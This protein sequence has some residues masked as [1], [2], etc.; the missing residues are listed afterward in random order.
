MSLATGQLPFCG[1]RPLGSPKR[2][3]NAVAEADTQGS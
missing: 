1:R 2:D 3:N